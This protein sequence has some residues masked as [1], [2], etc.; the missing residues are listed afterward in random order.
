LQSGEGLRERTTGNDVACETFWPVSFPPCAIE[1]AI[2]R[3]T[4]ETVVLQIK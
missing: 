1:E 3:R 2:D 4:V